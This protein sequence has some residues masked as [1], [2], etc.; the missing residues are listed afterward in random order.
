M[1]RST[2]LK[3]QTPE[4]RTE[5]VLSFTMMN[6]GKQCVATI[7]QELVYTCFL[8]RFPVNAN[9]EQGSACFARAVCVC[10]TDYNDRVI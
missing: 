10:V 5:T 6:S 9:V 4:C 2:S 7:F 1:N 8:Q 3:V